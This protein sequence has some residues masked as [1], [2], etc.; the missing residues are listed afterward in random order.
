MNGDEHVYPVAKIC[1]VVKG[2]TFWLTAGVVEGLSQP[3]VLGQDVLILPELVQSTKPVS[4]VATRSQGKAKE[5]ANKSLLDMMPFSQV[6]ISP[7]GHVKAQKS[8]RQRR[9]EKLQGTVQRMGDRLPVPDVPREALWEIPSNISE[10]QKADESLKET[11]R[12][13]TEV[14]GEK[15]G[16]AAALTGEYYFIQEGLLYHQPEGGRSEQL[17]VPKG[18]REKVLTLGH[19]I[20]WAGHLGNVKTL[21]RIAARFHWPGLYSEVQRYCK[22]CP[23]CQ[24]TSSHKV[25]RSP[26]HPLPIIGVPFHRIAMDIVGPLERTPSGH[27]FILV[28]CDYASRYPEAFPLRNITASAIAQALLQL[29]SRVGIPNEILRPGNCIPFQNTQTSLRFTGDKGNKDHSLPPSNGRAGRE[30][31]QNF[32]EHAEKVCC[33]QRQRLGPVATVPPFCLQGGAA[34]IHRVLAL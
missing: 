4:M 17:V 12:K 13:V 26:L 25:R 14:D 22:S 21:E 7:L 34:G 23:T 30:V 24:L 18:L 15:T 29:I 20:P 10:L 6:E 16:V 9:R 33:S 8:R 19:D 3:V 27:R 32:K 2:R 5:E 28:I 31:Q 1:L 11:F